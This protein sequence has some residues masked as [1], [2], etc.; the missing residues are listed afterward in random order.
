MTKKDDTGTLEYVR[1]G[2]QLLII[3]RKAGQEARRIIADVAPPN[4]VSAMAEH[5]Q[6][7]Q[8]KE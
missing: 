8:K 2:D 5:G 6:Q 7:Q 1:R 3:V 4:A